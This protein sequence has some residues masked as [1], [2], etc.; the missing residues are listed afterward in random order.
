MIQFTSNFTD[1]CTDHGYQFEFHCD[2]CRN[3]YMSKFQASV[4]GVA[5]GALKAAGALFGG[6]L[7]RGA[8]SL[9]YIRENQRGKGRDDAFEKAVQEG[10]THFKQCGRCSHW[11]CP[12]VCW[13]N[14]KQLC[15]DCAPDLARE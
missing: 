10:K 11:V 15:M 7:G 4:L 3:G 9:D 1:H 6:I 5:E 2:R 14:S 8:Q 12:D 13:N